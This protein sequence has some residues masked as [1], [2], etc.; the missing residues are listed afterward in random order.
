VLVVGNRGD[1]DPGYVGEAFAARGGELVA[2]HRD[3]GTDLPSPDG[4]DAVV[5]LGSEWSVYWEHVAEQVQA[6]EQLLREAVAATIP[7]LG[8]CYGGQLLAHA[9][10]GS[11]QRAPVAEIGWHSIDSDVPE[12][13]PTGPYVQWHYD[14]FTSPPGAV[15]LARSPAGPQAF[16]LGAAMG[17]QFH[18]EAT[19]LVVRRWLADPAV[20]AGVDTAAIID[21]ADR[22]DAAAR[23]R[24]DVLV[25]TFLTAGQRATFTR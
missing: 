4:F 23:I 11:V 12:M 20:L 3:D 8:V 16:V 9:L 5:C 18:P 17:V 14:R 7:V 21:E 1:N 2:V 25:Q 24:A 15:E 10:G 19:P 22:Q 6:E 13:I